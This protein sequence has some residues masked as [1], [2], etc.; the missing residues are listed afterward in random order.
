MA[1]ALDREKLARA[2]RA[3]NAGSARCGLPA[4][5]LM[6]DEVRVPDPLAAARALP[7]GSAVILR[8]TDAEAR[9]KLGHALIELVRDRRLMLLVAGD[10]PLAAEIGAHGL[11]LPEARMRDAVHWRALRP[12]WTITAAAHSARALATARIAGVDAALLAPVF[13]TPSH[14]ERKPLGLLRARLIAARAAIPV[15]ALGGVN[16]ET[17]AR[18]A[19]ANFAGIAAIGGLLS[20]QSV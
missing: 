1:S 10:A 16:A 13:A 17:V 20:D 18:L 7:R 11:H 3:L 9:A 12:W 14:P 19:H 6:T 4:L 15:Y 8:H 5:I 2:A